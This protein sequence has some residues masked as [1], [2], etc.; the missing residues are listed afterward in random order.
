[1]KIYK[2]YVKSATH[3]KHLKMA[4]KERNNIDYF[5]HSVNHGKKMFYL[6]D[7]YKNDGYA[8]W[9]MLLEELGKADYHFLDLKDDIQLM[10]LS[11]EFKVSELMLNEIISILVKFGEFDAE[12]WDNEKILFNLKFI[13]N[14]SDAYKKRNNDCITKNS[15]VELLTA[16]GRLSSSKS[17]PKPPK[18][19]PKAPVN[20]QSIVEYSIEEKIKEI[21]SLYPSKCPIQ[22]RSTS[23]GSKD[24]EK[25]KKLLN[26]ISSDKLILTIKTY[27]A[28]CET[29]KTYV[30]NFSSFLNNIP[31]IDTNEPV[32]EKR[33]SYKIHFTGYDNRTEQQYQEDFKHYGDAL[34]L[35]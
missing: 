29:S 3:L 33:Y 30:K 24:K 4:R 14:I 6:R 16:K 18:S 34:I 13:E 19:I 11:S 26:N 10:Y 9:F 31:D 15:L 1:M 32:K 8:V 12:L 23:K 20:P 7:K 35:R 17:I 22:N 21:Y 25:I 28:D 5:P 27:I 2:Y